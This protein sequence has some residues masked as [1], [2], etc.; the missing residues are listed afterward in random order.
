M[1][2]AW[3]CTYAL[4]SAELYGAECTEE[5]DGANESILTIA[6]NSLD[7]SMTYSFEVEVSSADGRV[8]TDNIIVSVSVAGSPSATLTDE[9]NR[10]VN[11]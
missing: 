5:M 4:A 9:K 8:A 1:S 11:A 7:P 2:Y 3:S 10:K 6:E